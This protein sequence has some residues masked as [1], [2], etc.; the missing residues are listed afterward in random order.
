VV[1]VG[2]GSLRGELER[3]T[4]TLGLRENVHFVG[5]QSNMIDW[6]ALADVTVLP[7][8]YEG[9]PLVAIESLAAGRPMVATD[10]DGTPEVVIDGR[11]GLMVPPG[12]SDRLAQALVRLLQDRALRQAMGRAGR[13]WVLEHFSHKRQIQKTQE[14]YLNA[15]RSVKVASSDGKQVAVKR[16]SE[17]GRSQP[18]A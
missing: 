14:F 13:S 15:W 10:V 17:S 16:V 4:A 18:G 9:L 3:L 1:C 12:D 8:F 2:E 5:Y 6:L 11:T 7:S